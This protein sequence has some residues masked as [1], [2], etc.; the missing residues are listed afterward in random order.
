[1]R[2]LCVIPAR[3]GSKR[4]PRKNIKAFMGKPIIAYAIEAALQSGLFNEVIVSTEDEEIANISKEYGAKIP[5]MRSW[6]TASDYATTFDVVEEVLSRYADEGVNFNT[7]CCL[8]PCTPFVT[9]SKLREANNLLIEQSYDVVFPIVSFSYP[10]QKT[11]REQNGKINYR[12]PEYST[13]RSQDLEEN[14]HDTGQFYFAKVDSLLAEQR[15]VTKNTGGIIVDAMECQDID[16]EVDW[17]IAELK[18]Q[19]FEKTNN[20]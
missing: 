16:H 14:Y 11:I 1:M 12:N 5:F 8:Y 9:S 15:F 13:T 18:F 2:S 7:I 4:I 3:G 17:K 6:D 20:I 19:I 10:I